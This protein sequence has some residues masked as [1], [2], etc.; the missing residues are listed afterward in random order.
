M[1]RGKRVNIAA[2]K[3]NK[4]YLSQKIKVNIGNYK[5]C[6]QYVPWHDVTKMVFFCCG[7]K[8]II[9][10]MIRKTSDKSWLTMLLL[11]SHSVV[12]NSFTTLCRVACQAPLSLGFPRQEYWSGLPFPSPGDLPDS[13]IE[14]VSPA[15]ASRFFTTVPPGKSQL[16]IL[17]HISDQ[18]S[19]KLS[20]S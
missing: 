9:N 5:S 12:S 17:Y 20:R 15:L 4:H 16:R 10:L 19:S 13:G 8:P 2:E 7:P 18:Q 6:W 11:F 1:E 3:S 14:P